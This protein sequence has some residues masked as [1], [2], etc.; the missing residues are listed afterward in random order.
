MKNCLFFCVVLLSPSSRAEWVE[1]TVV[2]WLIGRCWTSPSSRA[3]WV[4]IFKKIELG[5]M[6]V[7]L[8]PRGRSGLKSFHPF[9]PQRM[10]CL[11]PRG[12]SGLK[13]NRHMEH[14]GSGGRLRPRGR[15]GL[16]SCLGGRLWNHAYVSVLAGGVG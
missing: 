5:G 12:R 15:S 13:F 4:E 6:P 3:E 10:F 11:R 9:C 1:I 16:K 8:R 14:L 2:V 7:G